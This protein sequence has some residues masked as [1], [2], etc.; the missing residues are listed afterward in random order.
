MAVMILLICLLHA[1]HLP[2]FVVG[3]MCAPFIVLLVIN[4]M[5]GPSCSCYLTTNVQ[6]V[7]IP[8]PGR[9]NKVSLF[10]DF[11]ETKVPGAQSG[12]PVS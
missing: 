10:L 8:T 2:W 4:L 3:L 7:A 12:A 9:L 11:L 1:L 5:H 6:T